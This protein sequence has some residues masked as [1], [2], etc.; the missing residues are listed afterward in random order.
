MSQRTNFG[1]I[2]EPVEP[3]NLIEVQLKSY[4]EFLQ[5]G[6][7]PKKRKVVGLQAVFKEVFPIES[8]DQKMVLDFVQYEIGD[9]KLN[10]LEAIHEAET[11]SAPL[12]VTFELREDGREA[13]QERVYMGEIP[14]MS[15]RGTFVINGAERVVVSQLHRSPW[16]LFRD[17]DASQWTLVVWLPH[18]S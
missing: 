10:S 11:Y 17:P 6:I 2:H 14:L 13:R 8:Y 15:V 1:K 9:P 4:D 16:Y 3:P 5:R 7:E 18:H 12:Y